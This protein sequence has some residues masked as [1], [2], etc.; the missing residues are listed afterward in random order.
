MGL[1][2]DLKKQADQVRSQENQRKDLLAEN[3]A[4]VEA[5]MGKTFLYFLDLLKQLAVIKPVN[6]LLFSV[7]GLGEF[8]GL[9]YAEGS[10][11]YRK[12]KIGDVDY[13]ERIELYVQWSKPDNLVIERDMPATI[14]KASEQL[15]AANLKFSEQVFKILARHQVLLCV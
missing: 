14:K 4:A 6:P 5:A 11:D 7:P 9:A 8:A 13:Y 3:L 12:K 10:V 2:D 15:W 1:L